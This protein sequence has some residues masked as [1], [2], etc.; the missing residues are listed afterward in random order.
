MSEPLGAGMAEAPDRHG[1]FPRLDEDQLARLHALGETIATTP[2][3][4]LWR[5]GDDAYDF[6]VVESGAVAIVQGL[7]GQNRVIAEHARLTHGIAAARAT[8][9]SGSCVSASFAR[10]S[11]GRLKSA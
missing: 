8:V 10:I 7:G 2:G 4:V 1:A 5:E 3:Q 11:F 9:T 6:Y